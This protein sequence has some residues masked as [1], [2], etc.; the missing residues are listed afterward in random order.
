MQIKIKNTTIY[1]F[2]F[3]QN[4]FKICAALPVFDLKTLVQTKF[5]CLFDGV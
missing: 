1:F 4:F 2:L 3:V 5:V